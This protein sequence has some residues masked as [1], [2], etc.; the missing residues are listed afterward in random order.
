L[1]L[2]YCWRHLNL[3]RVAY[4]VFRNNQR[5]VSIYKAVGFRIKGRLKKLLFI[6]GSWLDVL[7]MATF[8][9]SRKRH[10]CTSAVR[11]NEANSLNHF[12][13]HQFEVA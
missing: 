7:L 8:R 13:L 3:N 11:Q 2:D 12:A 9:P 4:I 5:A 6:D 10:N 1:A